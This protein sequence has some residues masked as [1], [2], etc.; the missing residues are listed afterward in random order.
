METKQPY[1]PGQPVDR[2]S[3]YEQ[4]DANIRALLQFA[5]WMAVVLAV[6]L[7]AMRWTFNYFAKIEPRARRRRR[8]RERPNA[9]PCPVRSYRCI[10]MANSRITAR[11]NKNK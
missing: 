3:G 7:V 5:F 2:G 11:P 10:R 1:G 8:W 9:S 6:T 4:R